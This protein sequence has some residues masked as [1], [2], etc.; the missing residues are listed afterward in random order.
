MAGCSVVAG[1]RM[2]WASEMW[3]GTGR[4]LPLQ[5]SGLCPPNLPET[6]RGTRACMH[7]LTHAH[8]HGSLTLVCPSTLN[9]DLGYWIVYPFCVLG[10][11]L[12]ILI[13]EAEKGKYWFLQYKHLRPERKC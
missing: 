9:S 13:Q 7:T 6:G 8:A 5:L 11:I 3:E 1:G 10:K 12:E 2:L 4:T